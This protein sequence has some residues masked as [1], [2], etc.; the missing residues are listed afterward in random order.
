MTINESPEASA[1]RLANSRKK[2]KIREKIQRRRDKIEAYEAE[3]KTLVAALREL[4]VKP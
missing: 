1:Q 4:D 2:G 3:I